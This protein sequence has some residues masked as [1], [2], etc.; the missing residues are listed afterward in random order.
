MRSVVTRLPEIWIDHGVRKGAQGNNTNNHYT[1]SD[2]KTKGILDII[3]SY[4]C[5]PMQTTS[6]RGYVY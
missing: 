6:L 2:N 3:H 1:N 4:I 5:R